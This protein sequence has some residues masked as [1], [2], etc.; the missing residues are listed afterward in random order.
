MDMMSLMMNSTM[1]CPALT[2]LGSKSAGQSSEVSGKS[3]LFAS[4]LGG[5][6]QAALGEMASGTP[7]GVEASTSD[8]VAQLKS[9]LS[10]QVTAPELVVTSESGA[11][12]GKESHAMSVLHLL[13]LLKSQLGGSAREMN[14]VVAEAVDATG[15]DISGLLGQDGSLLPE[16]E[17]NLRGRLNFAVVENV[18][19][20]EKLADEMGGS[21][22]EGQNDLVQLGALL[23]A[24][25]G[26]IPQ[27]PR[28]S[29]DKNVEAGKEVTQAPI[30]V[31][32][33]E[34][35][36]Q[37]TAASLENETA[38]LMNNPAPEGAEPEM[39]VSETSGAPVLVR[40]ERKDAEQSQ[41]DASTKS[42]KL[43][44]PVGLISPVPEQGSPLDEATE[45]Q[46]QSS[47]K[48][49]SIEIVISEEEPVQEVLQQ[50]A[51][52]QRASTVGKSEQVEGA[53]QNASLDGKSHQLLTDRP[54]SEDS[55]NKI[56]REQIITQVREKLAE[57]RITQ[58]NGQITLRLN[59]AE[60]GE[61]KIM[62]RMDD[63]RL[64][65]EIVAEN[66]SVKDALMENLGSLK[67]ALARQ[68]LEM[69]QFDVSTGSR[70]FFNQG[71]REGRQQDQQYVATRHSGWLTGGSENLQPSGDG[72]WQR[73]NNALLDMMM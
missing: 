54:V 64:R 58:E 1:Q 39:A 30:A 55:P 14:G 32:L 38:V 67:E 28:Q 11:G 2:G 27:V 61:L 73:N 33:I 21:T 12:S 10:Q 62:V 16:I 66:R 15:V 47:S 8:L 59:P 57:H 56:T 63:Q 20:L 37:N 45:S 35:E 29:L 5:S 25:N 22:P 65:V 51:E 40:P 17:E 36:Q 24:L 50:S 4:L 9:L 43:Q 53:F 3:P 41:G 31:P 18:A 44:N 34:A 71:F 48:E 60:L 69:K 23:T 26:L 6:L 49:N 68:N 19:E 7:V 42:A 72:S 46:L 52:K 13:N 70:Q